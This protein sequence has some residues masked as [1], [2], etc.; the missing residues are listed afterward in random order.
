MLNTF[1]YK[2]F[3]VFFICSTNVCLYLCSRKQIN[4][5]IMKDKIKDFGEFNGLRGCM[6]LYFNT[7][8]LRT[9]KKYGITSATT[10]QDAYNILSNI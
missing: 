8:T 2:I 1:K 7:K 5:L 9:V 3:F 10:L 4:T 6:G